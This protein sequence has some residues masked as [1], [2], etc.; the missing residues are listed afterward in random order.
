MKIKKSLITSLL[1]LWSMGLYYSVARTSFALSRITDLS[2]VFDLLKIQND[3]SVSFVATVLSYPLSF[4]LF[5]AL[6]NLLSFSFI[7]VIII[8]AI[9]RVKYASKR[10]KIITSGPLLLFL[11]NLLV[12]VF[13][14][15]SVSVEK[16]IQLASSITSILFYL[17]VLGSVL[18]LI[19]CYLDLSESVES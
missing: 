17:G 10:F 2:S 12:L 7:F 13:A 15:Q 14:L 1:Y 19:F 5:Q 11:L 3:F 18:S 16:G 4:A 9:Y 6:F 8:Y